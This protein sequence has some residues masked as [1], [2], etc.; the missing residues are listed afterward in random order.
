[1]PEH[2]ITPAITP[3]PLPSADEVLLIPP[4]AD[5]VAVIA[6]GMASAAALPGGLTTVQRA[7]LEALTESM[8]GVAV[9]LS[10]FEPVGPRAFAEVLARRDA[11]F[12]NVPFG[13][14]TDP[15]NIQGPQIS[16]KQRERVLG[17]IETGVKEGAR[18]VVG[19]GRPAHLDK[20][21]FVEP[22]LFADVENSMTIAREEIFGPV[23]V[24]VP[25]DDDDDAVRIANDN[26]YGLAGMVTSASEERALA[27]ASRIRAGSLSVN[28]GVGYGAD[29]PF[30]GYKASGV[31]RQNGIEGFLQYLET[32]TIA[33][34]IQ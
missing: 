30:G 3:V 34:G 10:A 5:E 18:L 16:A 7:V 1:M 26:Q 4:T 2:S 17:Y 33:V 27:V 29:A 32:K 23:L 28:G 6:R 24:V 22:T 11:A 15:G 9:D 21:W 13:D 20:G 14:P 19:G 25:F 12:R 31:G 8:T